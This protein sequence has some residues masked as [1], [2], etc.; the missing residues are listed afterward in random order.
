PEKT[1]RFQSKS[2][3]VPSDTK[4]EFQPEGEGTVVK[5]QFDIEP[6]SYFRLGETFLKPRLSKEVEDSMQSLKKILEA[7][8]LKAAA[9]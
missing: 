3:P 4:Y 9:K 8:A 2:G 5:L 1:L 7:K 6:G